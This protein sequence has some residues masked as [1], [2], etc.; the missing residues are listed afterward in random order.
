MR[1]VILPVSI[2]AFELSKNQCQLNTEASIDS[3]PATKNTTQMNIVAHFMLRNCLSI[4]EVTIVFSQ[5][6]VNLTAR[7]ENRGDDKHQR[8]QFF[9]YVVF[10][11]VFVLPALPNIVGIL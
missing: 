11:L 8:I 7:Y 6:F 2:L 1:R 5:Q 9:H 3:I 10:T 4:L